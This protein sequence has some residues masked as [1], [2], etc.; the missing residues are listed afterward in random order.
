MKLTIILDSN[1]GHIV[2]ILADEPIAV[3]RVVD[4]DTDS[5]DPVWGPY[6]P[7]VLSVVADVDASATAFIRERV[8]DWV[9]ES[10]NTSVEEQK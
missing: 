3:V 7:G 10:E 8:H 1:K 5:N 4:I 2:Q 9:P 6:D